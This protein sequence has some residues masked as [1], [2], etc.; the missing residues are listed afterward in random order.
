MTIVYDNSSIVNG[1][2]YTLLPNAFSLQYG[3][4]EG[5]DVAE[6]MFTMT[7]ATGNY[8]QKL[9]TWIDYNNQPSS[10]F[11]DC[12]WVIADDGFSVC[13]QG[14]VLEFIAPW[15]GPN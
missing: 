9:N 10:C 15:D 1:P 4:L 14:P 6:T 7:N 13:A 11:G 12:I 5:T 8:D 3:L 2:E